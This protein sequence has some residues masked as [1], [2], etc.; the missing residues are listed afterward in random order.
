MGSRYTSAV[1]GAVMFVCV[2]VLLSTAIEPR[3]AGASTTAVKA[4]GGGNIILKAREKRT[5]TLHNMAR[6]NRGLRPLC[7]DPRLTKAARSHSREMVKK[8]YFSHTSYNGE[9]V[10]ARLRRFGYGR[11]VYGENI[12]G[13]YGS[14]AKA[15]R[16][17]GNWMDSA[18]HRSN[19]LD[20]KFRRV[21][22]GTYKGDYRGVGGYTMYTVDFG[23]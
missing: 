4:C 22:V 17:F 2:T 21:G 19:I 8:D 15:G 23:A 11:S 10:S 5:F 20:G 16:I 3:K 1:L 9:S 13:G 14:P 18:S 6:E 7:L 12:A